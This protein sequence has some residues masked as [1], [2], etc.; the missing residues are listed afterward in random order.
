MQST[1]NQNLTN[2]LTR[3]RA[4]HRNI[5]ENNSQIDP[6]LV[7]TQKRSR[8]K[9]E[10]LL[11]EGFGRREVGREAG[12]PW[13]GCPWL[14]TVTPARGVTS[15]CITRLIA[16]LLPLLAAALDQPPTPDLPPPLS[17]PFR[18]LNPT[19]KTANPFLCEVDS[20]PD[21]YEAFW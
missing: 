13:A 3:K 9:K 19:T 5:F 16:S 17:S 6:I 21:P 10:R 8:R 4:C 1:K 14:S 2:S 7:G 20:L 12:G 15:F 11:K 18:P